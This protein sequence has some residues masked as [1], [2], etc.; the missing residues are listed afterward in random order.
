MKTIPVYLWQNIYA[1]SGLFLY[2]MIGGCT[3]SNLVVQST[4]KIVNNMKKC[5]RCMIAEENDLTRF[6]KHC[7][8]E[9]FFIDRF[10]NKDSTGV[11]KNKGANMKLAKIIVD[12]T[13]MVFIVLSLLRWNGDPTFHIVVGSIFATLFMTHCLLNTKMFI[14]MSKKIGKLKVQMKLQYLVDIVLI[15]IWLVVIVAGIISAVSY[16]NADSTIRGIGRLHGMLGRIGCGFILIH[17]VQHIKQI[18]SYFKV[19]KNTI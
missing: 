3:D 5:P 10:L 2:L 14:S 18:R 8:T 19:C 6:C 12:I 15:I 13:M 17:I 4:E 7:G 16:I 11:K 9:L 1:N